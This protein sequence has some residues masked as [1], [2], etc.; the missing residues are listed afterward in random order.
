M[1]TRLQDDH[2]EGFSLALASDPGSLDSPLD[3]VHGQVDKTSR[4]LVFQFAERFDKI[5]GDGKIASVDFITK[6][7]KEFPNGRL[8]KMVLELKLLR[9]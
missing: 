8:R 3:P 4:G 2:S 7:N 1:V 9:V 6:P 5:A